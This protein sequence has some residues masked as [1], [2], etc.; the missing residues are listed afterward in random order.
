MRRVSQG[1]KP[2]R[3][4]LRRNGA[5]K[6]AN[7]TSSAASAR[8][9]FSRRRI[10]Q[11]PSRV[12]HSGETRGIL[13]RIAFDSSMEDV[14]TR[15]IGPRSGE[16]E[17]Q[18]AVLNGALILVAPAAWAA[19][20]DYT[21]DAVRPFQPT[22]FSSAVS[23]LPV[24]LGLASVSLLVVWRSYVHASAYRVKPIALW[25]GGIQRRIPESRTQPRPRRSSRPGGAYLNFT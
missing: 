16:P 12:I 25:R 18:A 22:L 3:L 13:A 9:C 11:S 21:W 20:V 24:L 1:V 10:S 7:V 15:R 4:G 23:A 19:Y 2:R 5:K 6:S 17:F 8:C 14:R